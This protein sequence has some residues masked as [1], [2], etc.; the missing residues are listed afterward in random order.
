MGRVHV[1]RHRSPAQE[2]RPFPFPLRPPGAKPPDPFAGAL[3]FQQHAPLWR[4]A[5]GPWA[6][7][8]LARWL[9]CGMNS[10]Q[11]LANLV[12]RMDD[13]LICNA[14]AFEVFSLPGAAEPVPSNQ[15]LHAGSLHRVK[16]IRGRWHC[17]CH[18]TP[19]AAAECWGVLEW[20]NTLHGVF[21]EFFFVK[22]AN[23]DVPQIVWWCPNFLSVG[24]GAMLLPSAH[25]TDSVSQSH[26]NV[27]RTGHCICQSNGPAAV[28]PFS[29][30]L[31]PFMGA[32]QGTIVCQLGLQRT[33][34]LIQMFPSIFLCR[35]LSAFCEIIHFFFET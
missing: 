14:S 29:N 25:A 35:L 1:G 28:D 5:V 23:S 15:H 10:S 4:L 2:A 27:T 20:T 9:E 31:E 26:C 32:A 6:N 18:I 12:C 17:E 13:F 33:K 21:S 22:K 19:C 30:T 16:E 3:C 8:W 34:K 24:G 7:E 11:Q